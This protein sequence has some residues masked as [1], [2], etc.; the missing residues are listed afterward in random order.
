[1]ALLFDGTHPIRAGLRGSGH[2]FGYSWDRPDSLEDWEPAIERMEAARAMTAVS[3]RARLSVAESK[4]ERVNRGSLEARLE[5]AEAVCLMYGW[6]AV[7]NQTPRQRVTQ[8]L[9]RR[10]V[11]LVDDDFLRPKAHPDL[12][13]M[14]NEE[15]AIP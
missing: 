6:S 3:E 5:A 8:E 9:W 12:V 14:E 10:W 2:G 7:T 1:M 15:E 13:A 4:A 11:G